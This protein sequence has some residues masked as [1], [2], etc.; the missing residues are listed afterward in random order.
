MHHEEAH[1]SQTVTQSSLQSSQHP[2]AI[3]L[4]LPA[5]S[6]FAIWHSRIQRSLQRGHDVAH[7][8]WQLTR[9]TFSGFVF[10]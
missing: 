2:R 6:F 9:C 8:S 3:C 10:G 5:L 4:Q 7:T 1:K